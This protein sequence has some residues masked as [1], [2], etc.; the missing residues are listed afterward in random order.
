MYNAYASAVSLPCSRFEPIRFGYQ[1]WFVSYLRT[2]AVPIS[3]SK[4]FM[5]LEL[6]L[7]ANISLIEGRLVQI[8]SSLYR[9]R[10]LAHLPWL[11]IKVNGSFV[12]AAISS[13]LDL[14]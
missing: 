8:Y 12:Y 2:I 14:Y 11:P 3:T 5:S 6:Y 1:H 4:I 10:A 9:R 7:N 13:N